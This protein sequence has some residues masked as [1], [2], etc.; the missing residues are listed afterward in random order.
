MLLRI[1]SSLLFFASLVYSDDPV[2]PGPQLIDETT[3]WTKCWPTNMT[4]Y[5]FS[6]QKLD[7][8]YIDLNQYRGK[9]L[10]IVNVATFCAYTQ[11][12]M[13][14]NPLLESNGDNL[15]ILAFPCN[16][17]ALQEPAENHEIMNG[18]THVRPGNGFK[19]H[20]NLQIYGK[21][22]VNG[23]DEHPL[24]EFLK[25]HC[26]PT[27][28]QIGKREELMY[29]PIKANDITWN[30]EKFLVDKEGRV[31]FRFHPTAWVH[32]DVLKP[33]IQQLLTEPR[34]ENYIVN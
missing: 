2:Q 22:E 20:R 7:G 11:Q 29:N 12:Y 16:Q 34:P 30:F 27:V 33:Y 26:P 28:N 23:K 32:G 24:Y 25:S 10:L 13:D 6:V 9:V 17:F 15:T 19:P 31:R 3:R 14:F 1:L 8:D 21:L 5:D 18:I 4:I